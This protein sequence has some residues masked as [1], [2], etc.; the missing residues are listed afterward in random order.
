MQFCFFPFPY[1]LFSLKMSAPN[2]YTF[3]TLNI[4]GT[5]CPVKRK[6][7]L[8]YLKQHKVDIALLQET[9]LTDSE[10]DKLKREWVGQVY[11]SSFT[12]RARGVA[13]LINKI[14]PFQIQS[15]IK[16]KGG[17]FVIIQGFFSTEPITNVN[18]Y[19]PNHDDPKSYQDIFLKLMCPSSE[20]IMAGDFNLVLDP[21]SDRSSSNSINLTQAAKMLKA[22]MKHYGLVDLW[23]FHNQKVKEY[24][25]YSPVHDSYSRIDLFLIP[26]AKGSLTT[27]C[28]YLPRCISDHSALLASVPVSREED[29]GLAHTC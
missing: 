24:S 14:C 1:F 21:S 22:E 12:S 28:K 23:R 17:R 25:F 26:A 8:Y 9:H 15:Q 18:V 7:I 3:M 16:D 29:G 5:K 2:N 20:I 19:G 4:R 10:H 11:Y 6:C 27:G 13:I